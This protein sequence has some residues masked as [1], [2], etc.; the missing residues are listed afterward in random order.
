MD[1]KYKSLLLNISVILAIFLVIIFFWLKN[2]FLPLYAEV[3]TQKKAIEAIE[4]KTNKILSFD[5]NEANIFFANQFISSSTLNEKLY[6]ITKR[7]LNVVLLTMSVSEPTKM[8]VEKA[9]GADLTAYS[10]Q[11]ISEVKITHYHMQVAGTYQAICSFLKD[12]YALGPSTFWEKLDLEI[13]N[14]PK[15][16]ASLDFYIM[17]RA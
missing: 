4:D 11:H 10:H 9:L 12:V 1:F 3:D 8:P 2:I 17:D 14:Y 6:Q 15:L 13:A 7:H 16:V 5:R